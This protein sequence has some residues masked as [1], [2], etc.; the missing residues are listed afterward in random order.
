MLILKPD[1]LPE[2]KTKDQ[3]FEI[4][5]CYLFEHQWQF[6]RQN[7]NNLSAKPER[8]FKEV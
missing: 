2:L 8:L 4:T 7:I 6:V 5:H 1:A 3:Q